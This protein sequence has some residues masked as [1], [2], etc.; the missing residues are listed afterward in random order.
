MSMTA[1]LNGSHNRDT[2]TGARMMRI[3]DLNVELLI[4][5]SISLARVASESRGSPVRSGTGHVATIIPSCISASHA[6]SAI[7]HWHAA[8]VVTPG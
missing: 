6:C 8:M 7:S 3:L 4:Y 5:G 2:L 1:L